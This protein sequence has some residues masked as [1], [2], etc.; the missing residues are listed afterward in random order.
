[1]GF[2]SVIY[3]VQLFVLSPA[4]GGV[5]HCQGRARTHMTHKKHLLLGLGLARP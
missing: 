4:F 5:L 2:V 1:M 3:L